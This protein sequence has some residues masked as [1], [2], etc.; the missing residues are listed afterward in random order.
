[1]LLLSL[2]EKK[3]AIIHINISWLF[4]AIFSKDPKDRSEFRLA[5]ALRSISDMHVT[6]KVPQAEGTQIFYR[7]L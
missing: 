2:L 5:D 6:G 7:G 3:V 1:M 4:L